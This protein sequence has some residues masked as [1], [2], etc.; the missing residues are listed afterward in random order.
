MRA[1]LWCSF[2]QTIRF[3]NEVSD[4]KNSLGAP[5]HTVASL[6]PQ[7]VPPTP[8]RGEA[9][10]DR[11]D[12]ICNCPLCQ[13]V[14]W[15][16][17]PAEST[18]VTDRHSVVC[19]ITSHGFNSQQG[20]LFSFMELRLVRKKATRKTGR[21]W[22]SSAAR[23]VSLAVV[24]GCADRDVG[25]LLPVLTDSTLTAACTGSGLNYHRCAN[26]KRHCTI[27]MRKAKSRDLAFYPSSSSLSDQVI[28]FNSDNVFKGHNK[29]YHFKEPNN[30]YSSFSIQAL[31]KLF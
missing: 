31:I 25:Q 10:T 5:W 14:N 29:N 7:A 18:T 8:W 3:S 9:H 23:K 27:V 11:V 16:D 19:F 22:C 24:N 4:G 13:V 28:P 1:K 12:Q 15:G 6:A 30:I 26:W 21:T 17:Q 20:L 2:T